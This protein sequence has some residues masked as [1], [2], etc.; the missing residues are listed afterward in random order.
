MSAAVKRRPGFSVHALPHISEEDTMKV[1]LPPRSEKKRVPADE[2]NKLLTRKKAPSST[3]AA[4]FLLLDSSLNP[5]SFNA[6]ATQILS[7]P[8]KVADLKRTEVFLAAKI[9]STLLNRPGFGDAPF[10]TEFRSGRRRYFCR[11]FVVDSQAEEPGQPSIAVLLERGPS[12]LVPLRRVIG[13]FNLTQR[14]REVLEYLLQGMSSKAI[15]D[16]MELSPNTVKTFLR[17]I[18]IKMGV[19][20]RSA[21]VSKIIMTQ[22]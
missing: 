5:I 4:G 20:S 6:E 3:S 18:M 1:A 16:R 13:Q 17:L 7:Y 22:P 19:T 21:I 14:E 11:A 12:G 15:A 10:V 9:H 8:E 2:E